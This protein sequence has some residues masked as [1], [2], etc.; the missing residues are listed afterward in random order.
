MLRVWRGLL[1]ALLFAALSLCIV[2]IHLWPPKSILLVF[3]LLLSTFAF[4]VAR[5]PVRPSVAWVSGAICLSGFH[6]ALCVSFVYSSGQ[7]GN[8]LGSGPGIIDDD[9]GTHCPWLQSSRSTGVPGPGQSVSF[10]DPSFHRGAP[11]APSSHA[12]S[13]PPQQ[14]STSINPSDH[15]GR[16]DEDLDRPLPRH[17][18]LSFINCAAAL[19]VGIDVRDLVRDKQSEVGRAQRAQSFNPYL[20]SGPNRCHA[21]LPT[22]APW[23]HVIGVMVV[24][25]VDQALG[26]QLDSD[27]VLLF[28]SGHHISN[29]Q[30]HRGNSSP[31]SIHFI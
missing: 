29:N 3:C 16:S 28:T 22:H 11:S 10:G 19:A 27:Q 17:D 5:V 20:F 24:A 8:V 23:S 2:N 12:S 9:G 4:G 25:H 21:R 30:F 14:S 15:L 6:F 7:F 31:S 18:G 13:H 1:F 26:E